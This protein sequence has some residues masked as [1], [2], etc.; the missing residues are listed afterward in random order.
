MRCAALP[1]D[2]LACGLHS[3]RRPWFDAPL[4]RGSV[5]R[6]GGVSQSGRFAVIAHGVALA[7][8]Q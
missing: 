1:Q 3:E 4:L 5:G 6:E 2:L 8:V 7:H